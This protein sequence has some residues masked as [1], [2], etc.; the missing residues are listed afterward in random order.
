[1]NILV[2]SCVGA[3]AMPRQQVCVLGTTP[4]RPRW[5]WQRCSAGPARLGAARLRP[6]VLLVMLFVLK[7][8]L[9][10]ELSGIMAQAV[11]AGAR[12]PIGLDMQDTVLA[13][14]QRGS[15]E[16][17]VCCTSCSIRWLAAAAG[18]CWWTTRGR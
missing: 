11:Q 14:L 18:R 9:L 15:P 2:G 4:T 3:P 8:V 16:F 6:Q 12:T 5:S 17:A 10:S 13:H 1:M 7:V